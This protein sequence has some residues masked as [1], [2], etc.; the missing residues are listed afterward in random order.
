[1]LVNKAPQWKGQAYSTA[2]SERER[3]RSDLSMWYYNEEN[4]ALL[5]R[6]FLARKLDDWESCKNSSLE[7]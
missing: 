2:I 4:D 3:L 5:R 6:Q 1:M 7:L